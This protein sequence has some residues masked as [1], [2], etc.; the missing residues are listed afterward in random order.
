[1]GIKSWLKRLRAEED[2]EAIADAERVREAKEGER[3]LAREDPRTRV[4]DEE[5]GGGA[6]IPNVD[7][8]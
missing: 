6:R 1:M 3:W 5:L 4:L 7:E 2:K 8:P